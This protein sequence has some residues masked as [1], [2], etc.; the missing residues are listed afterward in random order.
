MD[1]IDKSQC[2]DFN[3][4]RFW[5]MRRDIN[6]L[7]L[8]FRTNFPIK[9]PNYRKI[10]IIIQWNLHWADTFGTF[11]SVLL[12]YRGC[13]LNGVCKNCAMFNFQRLLC[14]VIKFHF[15]KEAKEAALY[16]VQDSRYNLQFI[17][18]RPKMQLESK[19]LNV[20]IYLY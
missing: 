2:A 12:I 19:L 4:I 20:L 7:L 15:V 14:T 8:I 9:R 3:K 5:S 13:P 11:P 17:D 18:M 6:L 10:I 1:G 16:F